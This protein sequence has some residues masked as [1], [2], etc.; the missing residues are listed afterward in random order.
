MI[1]SFGSQTTEDLYH[2]LDTR[3]ARKIPQTVWK[4]AQRKLD[5][6]NT[7]VELKD[8]LAFPAN[9]FEKLKGHRAGKYSIRINDQYR[10]VFKFQEG[11]A[12]QVEIVDYH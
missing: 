7:A 8:F 10:I 5:M 9:R 3:E 11:N 1:Q 6:I 4:T 12:F 2:G